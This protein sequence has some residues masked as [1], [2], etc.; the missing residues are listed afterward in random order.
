MGKLRG[1]LLE[2]RDTN[3]PL[4]PTTW[5]HQAR[6]VRRRGLTRRSEDPAVSEKAV[7]LRPVPGG[8]WERREAAGNFPGRQHP[9]GAAHTSTVATWLGARWALF[10]A[11]VEKE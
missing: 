4:F 1:S 6:R 11:K 5:A 8:R 9:R 10:W 7:P 3:G 2:G